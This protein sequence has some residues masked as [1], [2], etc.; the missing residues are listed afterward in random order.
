LKQLFLAIAFWAVALPV[1]AESN[2]N[3]LAD[4]LWGDVSSAFYGWQG[5]TIVGGA[6]AGSL[7]FYSINDQPL[8]DSNEPGI[9]GEGSRVLSD[10]GI[11]LPISV[12]VAFFVTGFAFDPNS[13][14]R[15]ESWRTAEE[16]AEALALALATTSLLKF[17]VQRTRPNDANY[18]F[19]SAHSTLAFSSAGILA[20]R[21]PWYVGVPALALASAVGFSRIDLNE[22]FASDV[23]AGAG[24]GLLF[25]TS[26]HLF[27][28][29]R[30]LGND[31]RSDLSLVPLLTA[32]TRGIL[33]QIRL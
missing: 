17:T 32:R 1:R 25:A 20:L 27:H 2:L 12:P 10:V 16:S 19:P 26:V 9:L 15:S 28:Q 3:W 23:L 7:L 31:P 24:I 30:E 4:H 21:Y 13:R 29:K 11:F 18:S 6:T 8:G 33:L 22:H 5:P 14:V